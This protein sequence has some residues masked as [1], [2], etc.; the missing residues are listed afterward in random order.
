[1]FMVPA[2]FYTFIIIGLFIDLWLY[3]QVVAIIFNFFCKV[4][5]NNLVT[6]KNVRVN[7]TLMV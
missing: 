5:Q 4:I 7:F 6:S 1:M 2:M 3:R